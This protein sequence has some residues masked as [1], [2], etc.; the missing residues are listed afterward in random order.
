MKPARFVTERE[1]IR[2]FFLP[3]LC[4]AGAVFLLVLVAELMVCVMVLA[5]TGVFGIDWH[6]LALVSLFVQWIVLTSAAMMCKLRPLMSRLPVPVAI[7]AM[8][9]V[10]QMVTL[11]FTLAGYYCISSI[12]IALLQPWPIF[13]NLLVALIVSGMVMR[14]FYLAQELKQKQEAELQARIQALQSRIRPHFLFNSMN[15][16]ASLIPV[17]PERAEQAVEDLCDLF[18]A[19]LREAGEQVSLKEEIGLCKRYIRIEQQR[20]GDRLGIMWELDN[21]PA[22]LKVPRLSLQPLLENAICHGIQCLPEGG[23]IEVRLHRNSSHAMIEVIN[24]VP[25]EPD[26]M[27]AI[28]GSHLALDN[29]TDRLQAHY[30]NQASL[31]T[32]NYE[33]GGR[34]Y[35]IAQIAFPLPFQDKTRAI[36]DHNQERHGA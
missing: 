14:Y 24:P 19:S 11:F 16:I 29:I 26:Q 34:P 3:D 25:E 27:A 36:T 23:T 12:S 30:G 17:A 8:L 7:I 20:F 13:R 33:R 10:V 15:I 28:E 6:K 5:E 1:A 4:T 2:G 21:M 9:F 18:R 31:H 35:F 32:M 22:S